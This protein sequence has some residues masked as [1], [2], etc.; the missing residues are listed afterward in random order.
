MLRKSNWI[1]Q[2]DRW[3]GSKN[4]TTQNLERQMTEGAM[5]YAL[6]A[7][8]NKQARC[9]SFGTSQG[10]IRCSSFLCA[11]ASNSNAM[12]ETMG[13]APRIISSLPVFCGFSGLL[14]KMRLCAVARSLPNAKKEPSEARRAEAM[15]VAFDSQLFPSLTRM[16][17]L[18]HQL[19]TQR[20]LHCH[21]Q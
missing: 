12:A 13:K 14:K 2:L 10:G 11:Q 6:S 8:T 16:M 19:L 5:Y 20:I 3:I 7:S 17:C 21:H 4:R 9:S 15:R 18:F 1:D